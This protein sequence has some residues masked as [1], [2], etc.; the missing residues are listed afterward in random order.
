MFGRFDRSRWC[1][2]SKGFSGSDSPS[3]S[4]ERGSPLDC[5]I[6]DSDVGEDGNDDSVFCGT[7][8]G[9]MVPARLREEKRPLTLG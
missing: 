6:E 8:A 2:L 1:K 4:D 5:V 3:D 9:V 7:S